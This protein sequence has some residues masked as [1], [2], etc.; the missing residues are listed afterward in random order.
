MLRYCGRRPLHP[1]RDPHNALHR[2]YVR[3]KFRYDYHGKASNPMPHCHSSG[4]TPNGLRCHRHLH[5]YWHRCVCHL[6]RYSHR[7]YRP[8]HA[9]FDHCDLP[10][11]IMRSLRLAHFVWRNPVLHVRTIRF[12]HYCPRRVERFVGLLTP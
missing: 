5:N 12:L 7:W 4:C 10:S 3:Q 1:C 2:R 9:P 8:I 11:R 6:N